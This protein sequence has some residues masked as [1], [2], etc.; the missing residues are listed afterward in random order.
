[1]H[2]MNRAAH[3]PHALLYVSARYIPWHYN[4]VYVFRAGA[5]PFIQ[6]VFRFSSHHRRRFSPPLY[7]GSTRHT[8]LLILLLLLLLLNSIHIIQIRQFDFFFHSRC[9]VAR[10]CLVLFLLFSLDTFSSSGTVFCRVSFS[11]FHSQFECI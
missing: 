11:A 6:V 9:L 1:M 10:L 2:G 7:I 3:R 4:I 8:Q 5:A